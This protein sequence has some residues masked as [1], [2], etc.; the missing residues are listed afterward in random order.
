MKEEK[1]RNIAQ[2]AEALFSQGRLHEITMED[3]ARK[4][5][6]GK[7]TLYRYVRD[8]EDLLHAVATS[9]FEELCDMV[10]SEGE[11]ATDFRPFLL[12]MLRTRGREERFND[13]FQADHEVVIELFLRGA[14][15]RPGNDSEASAD[16]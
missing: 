8:K 1:R 5:A 11:R 2:V 10:R 14:A 4:A 3:I 7:G 12:G 16:A 9:G 15:P 13:E 6:V